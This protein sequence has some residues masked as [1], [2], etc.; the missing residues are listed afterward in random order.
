MYIY[1]GGGIESSYQLI[2]PK[3]TVAVNKAG[4]LTFTIYPSN[5]YYSQMSPYTDTFY[6]ETANGYKWIGRLASRTKNKDKGFSCVCE[7]ALAFL[8][9]SLMPPYDYNH[10]SPW[11]F[12]AE[13]I[14]KHNSQ[15]DAKRK[16][17]STFDSA[18]DGF[19]TE[20]NNQYTNAFNEFSDK[21]LKKWPIYFEQN[22]GITLRL[23]MRKDFGDTVCSQDVWL[24]NNLVNIQ[25][26][27]DFKNCYT[28]LYAFGAVQTNG[29]GD[30]GRVQLSANTPYIA[31]SD[32]NIA[33]YGRRVSVARFNGAATAAELN[34]MAKSHWTD[35]FKAKTSISARGVD[36]YVIGTAD[37]PIHIGK[38]VRVISR[39]HGINE[40][41][42]C[43]QI[44]YDLANPANDEYH[45]GDAK[46]T[47]SEQVS[48]VASGGSAAGGSSSSGNT[49]SSAA[50]LFIEQ[51]ANWNT[52][53]DSL[54]P[55][56]FLYGYNAANAPSTSAH[57]LGLEI[58]LN[59]LHR[60]QIVIRTNSSTANPVF[61]RH[62]NNGAWLQWG[63][64]TVSAPG[65]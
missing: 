16:I 63:R 40:I 3:L 49:G 43:T 53:F 45:F 52:A 37:E 34:S 5:S 8:N 50:S 64:F 42:L 62:C 24:G 30:A 2:K 12:F 54:R 44:T 48:G 13:L 19:F 20:T 46:T 25:K 65:A 60:T 27:E 51:V 35:A 9:D 47:L 36:G 59:S 58:S 61:I 17:S 7:G 15:V 22:H 55:I 4:S 32:T 14:S 11:E 57:F 26:T 21:L 39:P 56:R 38:K 31:R 41:L 6:V 29:K 1:V 10:L 23:T 33:T 28:V 18:P